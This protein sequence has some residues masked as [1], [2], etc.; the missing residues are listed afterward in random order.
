MIEECIALEIQAA[1]KE[2]SQLIM[3]LFPAIGKAIQ[4]LQGT[5]CDAHL[6]TVNA[7]K[8][9][10]A[11]LEYG[12]IENIIHFLH[13]YRNH[14][15]LEEVPKATLRMMESEYAAVEEQT[16]ALQYYTASLQQPENTGIEVYTKCLKCILVAPTATYNKQVDK[17]K[18]LL[19]VKKLS[20]GPKSN[21]KDNGIGI[22]DSG[23]TKKSPPIPHRV[24][25]ATRDLWHPT[26]HK[27][28]RRH[29]HHPCSS[30]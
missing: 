24:I 4:Q 20:N 2:E 3:D 21:N 23:R 29:S 9:T 16:K 22:C 15:T 27:M 19:I 8:M 18:R 30:I 1:K 12:P 10:P 28:P 6:Q 13:F 7:L 17:N 14:H 5:D 25:A 26:L 11:L